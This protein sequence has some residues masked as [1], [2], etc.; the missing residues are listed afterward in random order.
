VGKKWLFGFCCGWVCAWG[1]TQCA[2]CALALNYFAGGLFLIFFL[3]GCR[4]V[5]GLHC[6]AAVKQ[7]SLKVGI[8]DRPCQVALS[9]K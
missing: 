6:Q 9:L 7:K 3:R 8:K 1:K 5:V 2:I 4:V